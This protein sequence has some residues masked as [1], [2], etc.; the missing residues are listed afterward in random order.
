[1]LKKLAKTLD[2]KER[3]WR[4]SFG[5]NITDPVERRKSV[6][7]YNMFDHAFLRAVWTNYYP[8]SKDVWRSNQP[9]HKRFMKYRD[10]GIRSVINLR[11]VDLQCHYLFEKESCDM[12]G[13]ELHSTV[14]WA[15][16][17]ANR[18]NIV[19]VIDLMR[20]VKKPMMFHCKSGAD[21]AGF[22]AAMYQM[23]FD[24]VPV[25]K[26][27]EQL[28]LKFIHLK[29]GKTGVQDYILDVFEARQAK[30]DIDFETWIRTEYD[31]DVIQSG[32]D[33]KTPPAQIA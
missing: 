26:A 5:R 4:Y 24:G 27:R 30:S 14:L 21:R 31:N 18:E 12:L 8:V 25:Q 9:T 20:T 22:C 1:M 32:F 6:W 10:M 23:I 11:G 7:H 17:A 2:E 16:S 15:R 3:Q 19:A 28:S 13:I 33:S 29:W